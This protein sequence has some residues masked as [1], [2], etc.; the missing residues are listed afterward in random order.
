VPESVT[1]ELS[2]L[3]PLSGSVS[4]SEKDI[5][6]PQEMWARRTPSQKNEATP[7]SAPFGHGNH[8][9]P[10]RSVTHEFNTDPDR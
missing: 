2:V 10:E 7:I 6:S 4:P 8:D 5:V 1:L 3:S 9:D